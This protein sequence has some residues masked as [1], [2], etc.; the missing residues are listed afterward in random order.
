MT[1][2]Y[3]R[4]SN[5]ISWAL[6]TNQLCTFWVSSDKAHMTS[7]RTCFMKK[8][9]SAVHP[10]GKKDVNAMFSHFPLTCLTDISLA[11]LW[12][13]THPHTV[14]LPKAC[15]QH[16]IHL[17]SYS[18]LL[19]RATYHLHATGLHLHSSQVVSPE[20]QT[21]I[22][23]CRL[24]RQIYW[25]QSETPQIQQVQ[26]QAQYLPLSPDLLSCNEF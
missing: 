16:F 7:L 5:S 14:V 24:S 15:L 17:T 26:N 10:Q 22:C 3:S 25:I 2:E 9:E 20:F 1:K 18:F 6:Q 4:I 11:P 23:S 13:L 12:A 19:S 21:L 8:T